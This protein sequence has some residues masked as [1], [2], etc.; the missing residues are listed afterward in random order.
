M[1]TV[2]LALL[3]RISFSSGAPLTQALIHLGVVRGSAVD[4]QDNL[5]TTE[6]EI[7]GNCLEGINLLF[8]SMEI[9][10]FRIMN[11]SG[12]AVGDTIREAVAS[13]A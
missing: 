4:E 1:P 5:S 2:A 13:A 9:E 3:F 8:T 10:D 7:I 11:L 6:E 12:K